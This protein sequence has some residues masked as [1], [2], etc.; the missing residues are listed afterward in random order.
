MDRMK[1]LVQ[2]NYDV[3]LNPTSNDLEKGL[4]SNS[5]KQWTIQSNYINPIEDL[6]E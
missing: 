2:S 4:S 3:N 1:I 5:N 6:A